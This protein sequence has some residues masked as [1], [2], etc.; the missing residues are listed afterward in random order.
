MLEQAAESAQETT[1]AFELRQLP[2][3]QR[4]IYDPVTLEVSW[5]SG[6]SLV[7]RRGVFSAMGGFDAAAPRLAQEA[8]FTWRM[9][10]AGLRTVYV[11]QAAV[12]GEVC[13]EGD[14]LFA[15]ADKLAANFYLRCKFGTAADVRAFGKEYEAMQRNVSTTAEME[16]ALRAQLHGVRREKSALRRFYRTRVRES[17]FA[18]HFY[19]LESAFVRSGASC[20][21]KRVANGP[22]F[23]VIVRT[24]A[25]PE[26]LALTLECLRHQT[27]RNFKVIV[28]EDGARPAARVTAE[29]AKAF[30]P[31]TYLCADA[32]WGRCKAGNAGLAAADTP[33][34]CFLD[35]DD[36]FYADHLETL[37]ALALEH[38]GC[39]LLLAGAVEGA[40]RTGRDLTEY[41]FV[42]L[43]NK[44]HAHLRLVDFFTENPIPIQAAAFKRELFV[45]HGGLDEAMDALEDWDLWLR[46]A[47]HTPFANTEKATSL[48]RIP[49]DK[50]AHKKRDAVLRSYEGALYSRMA[51]YGG[52][53]SAQDVFGLFYQQPAQQNEALRAAA[54]SIRRSG[55]WKLGAPL[56][57]LPALL[58]A[59]LRGLALLLQGLAT[60]VG[61]AL[62]ALADGAAWVA[63]AVRRAADYVG[64]AAPAKDANDAELNRFVFAAR[65]SLSWR[66]PGLKK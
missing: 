43:W 30:L 22:A 8:D 24:K 32:D 46:Y 34:V 38:P 11:P 66:L 48:Y 27:Y 31:L 18:P 58:C 14:P 20:E 3:E 64:P 33:Y 47:T 53:V 4:K 41:R 10:C 45:Q 12:C 56:R 62:Q 2:H 19:G 26:V 28:V 16:R 42:R 15:L 40:C 17:G 49:A 1:A 65:T 13:A 39:G 6:R 7:V 54:S 35:D 21:D 25:R 29:A 9:R 52:R 61:T 23:T 63:C 37:A 36:Y 50:D 60:G 51:A 44:C 5:A 57:A 59:V 55:R